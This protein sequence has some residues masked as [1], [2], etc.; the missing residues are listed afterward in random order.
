MHGMD[1][2]LCEARGVR[3]VPE[4]EIDGWRRDMGS[5]P[6]IPALPNSGG[7]VVAGSHGGMSDGEA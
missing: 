7:R 4:A 2:V 5:G 3:A 1:R 6:G